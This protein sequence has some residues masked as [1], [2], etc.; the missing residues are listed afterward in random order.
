M[1][2]LSQFPSES[3]NLD[4]YKFIS[5]IANKNFEASKKPKSKYICFKTI[6]H[7][8]ISDLVSFF[9]WPLKHFI[10]DLRLFIVLEMGL[11]ARFYET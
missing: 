3:L 7:R 5:P 1:S 2:H 11:F 8:N 10:F 6:I 9:Y 4:S